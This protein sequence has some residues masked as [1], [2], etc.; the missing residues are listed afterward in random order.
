[1]HGQKQASLISTL[2]EGQGVQELDSKSMTQSKM[3]AA[4]A[5]RAQ[6]SVQNAERR[7]KKFGRTHVTGTLKGT[8][9]GYGQIGANRADRSR[10][11]QTV[12]NPPDTLLFLQK[13]NQRRV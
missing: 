4:P 10:V 9:G 5:Q 1:M 6:N 2:S 12:F 7:K 13:A 8:K 11:T 3:S